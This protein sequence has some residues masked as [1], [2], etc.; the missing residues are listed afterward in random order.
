VVL[1][2]PTR[3]PRLFSLTAIPNAERVWAYEVRLIF[4]DQLIRTRCAPFG[5]ILRAGR[6]WRHVR[7]S[8]KG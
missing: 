2:L 8:E 6:L 3:H 7:Q 4:N 5:Q 1:Q